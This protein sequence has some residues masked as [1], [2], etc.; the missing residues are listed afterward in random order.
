MTFGRTDGVMDERI[1]GNLSFVSQELTHHL[2]ADCYLSEVDQLRLD[3]LL[4]VMHMAYVEWKQRNGDPLT[5]LID[6]A[7]KT[8]RDDSPHD[9][10]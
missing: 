7:E 2:K 4:A 8:H 9:T 3:N 1:F 6:L 10:V 5:H